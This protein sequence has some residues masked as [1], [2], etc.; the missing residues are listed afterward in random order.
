M[1]W[2][3]M[4]ESWHNQI[5]DR[6]KPALVTIVPHGHM[7]TKIM[8]TLSVACQTIFEAN[9]DGFTTPQLSHHVTVCRFG[10]TYELRRVLLKAIAGSQ[11]LFRVAS[12]NP[13][14]D[15]SGVP[16]VLP[17]YWKLYIS[18]TLG[19]GIIRPDGWN[20]VPFLH[21]VR[22]SGTD[23]SNCDRSALGCL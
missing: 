7:L 23:S 14:H 13:A 6:T 12:I 1:I 8:C 20:E 18:S 9:L 5:V 2:L 19:L 10:G 4:P 21:D 15:H 3:G 22:G 16:A 11:I 17:H